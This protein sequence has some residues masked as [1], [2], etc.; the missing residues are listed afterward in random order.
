MK[1]IS[2]LLRFFIRA[3]IIILCSIFVAYTMISFGYYYFN[4]KLD[5][6]NYFNWWYGNVKSFHLMQYIYYFIGF[7]IILL[8]IGIYYVRNEGD[9]KTGHEDY[10]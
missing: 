3:N 4:L 5:P 6:M 2:E 1:K 9:T 8:V 10:K 7:E